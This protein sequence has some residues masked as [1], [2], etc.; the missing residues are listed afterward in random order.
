MKIRGIFSK[1]IIPALVIALICGFGWFGYSMFHGFRAVAVG[2]EYPPAEHEHWLADQLRERF[3][4][5]VLPPSSV[6]HVWANGFQDHTWLFR[7][8]LT[9]D[10]FAGLRR[11]VLAT[12]GEGMTSD[13]RDD[14]NLCPDGFAT[15][16]PQGPQGLRIPA[17]WEA[18]SLRHFDS[19]L[20]QSPAWGY[21]FGY[22][23]ERQLLF[24][25]AYNT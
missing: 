20:W 18:A 25:L 10:L 6:E 19:I 11:S 16:S 23:T 21:W 7:I 15:A 22:D 12:H 24:L 4:W 1:I 17:W 5:S 8:R 14:L 13:D 2:T 9:P 3:S